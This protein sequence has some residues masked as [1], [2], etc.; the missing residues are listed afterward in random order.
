M[1]NTRC[2]VCHHPQRAEIEAAHVAGV[3]FRE[4]AKQFDKSK[5]T[6][7]KPIK[8][9]VPAAAQKALEAANDREVQAGDAILAE[10]QKLKSEARRLQAHA[11]GKKDYRGALTAVRELTRLV[12]LSARLV[13]SCATV[14][15]TSAS[16]NIDP[17]T[18]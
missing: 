17:D 11:E 16:S 3:A 8:L 4:I 6:I 12:E 15:S 13:V 10:V 9:H 5:T 18:A 14:Q 7:Q 1:P 2:T